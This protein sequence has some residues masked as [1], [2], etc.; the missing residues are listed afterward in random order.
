MIYKEELQKIAAEHGGVLY[1]KDVVN[2]ARN[3]N[4]P[5]H[6]AFEWDDGIAAEKFR[7]VQ[8]RELIRVQVTMI[9]SRGTPVRAFVSLS[10]DRV[11]NGGYFPIEQV[12]NTEKLR[13]QMLRD[14]ARDLQIFTTKFREIEELTKVNAA[15]EEFLAGRKAD[16][17]DNVK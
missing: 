1:P 5:L 4:S 10:P 17:V 9:P 6:G 15:A 3:P 13:L 7:L 8:A 2:A 14:A 11:E 12:M 16:E